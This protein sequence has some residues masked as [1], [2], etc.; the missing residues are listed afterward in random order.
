ME[1]PLVIVV[2][3]FTSLVWVTVNVKKKYGWLG[4]VYLL[5]PVM[6]VLGYLAMHIT[7]ISIVVQD[8]F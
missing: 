5:I 6:L 8:P 4:T 1:I 3:A 7:G 2:F